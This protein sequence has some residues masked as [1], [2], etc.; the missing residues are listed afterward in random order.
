MPILDLRTVLISY[1]CGNLIC[2]IVLISLW[3]Q[4]RKRYS[5]LGYWS[6]CFICNLI[7]I[8]LLSGRGI[9]PDFFSMLLGSLF[10]VSGTFF[11]YVGLVVFLR[12]SRIEPHIYILMVVYLFLQVYFIYIKPNFE[13]RNILF[14]VLLFIFSIQFAWLLFKQVDASL[15]RFTGMLGVITCIFGL[16]AVL[17]I[18]LNIVIYPGSA[19]QHSAN[20]EAYL[21]LAFQL[22]YVILTIS[23]F[24]LVNR[25]LMDELEKDI[26][27][28]EEIEDALRLS[29]EKF[30]KA[31]QAS[32]NSILITRIS[33]GRIIDVNDRFTEVTGFKH[34][35]VIDKTTPMINFWVYPDDRNRM[36]QE[37]RQRLFVKNME[38]DFRVKSGSIFRGEISA[39][40]I[41]LGD[42]DCMLSAIQDVTERKRMEDILHL[43]LKLWE[44]SLTHTALEVMVKALDEIED[45]TGSQIGFY[46]LVEED[47]N[48]LTLQAWSTRTKNEYCHAEGSGM[49]Y[50]IDEAGIWVDCIRERKTVIHN[51]YAALPNKHGL[52]EG[53]SPLRRELLVPIFQQDQIVSV[54]GV[55]NKPTEYDQNDAE[56]VEYI[57]NLVWSIVAQKRADEKIQNL[58]EKL[59]SLAMVDEL[60][61]L[62]NRRAFFMRGA[63]EISRSKRYQ[64]PLTILMLDIDRFKNINDTYGHAI[65]DAALQCFAKTLRE[66]VREVD[67]P[68]RLG[69][70]EF[71]ILLP[72]TKLEEAQIIAERVRHAIE[73]LR[74]EKED[75]ICVTMTASIGA[76]EFVDKTKNLDDLFS[77]ADTAMYNAKN[78]GRNR[79]EVFE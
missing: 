53:H 2:A 44:Y 26:F 8:A 78:N 62:P 51:D 42:D 14:S 37:M 46:H 66:Q 47:T 70:E 39:E 25:R 11:L 69:G 7:G 31:F 21:Y 40:Y 9:I 5:G 27:K 59:A 6:V 38:F 28:R 16:L 58:N 1:I 15:R 12:K 19:P 56:F 50:S 75:N 41:K 71:G 29:R 18:V 10:L 54:L 57:A 76:A 67:V 36:V 68:A 77:N 48:T 34:D 52:P 49:H 32:P 55:G 3:L 30:A 22:L 61:N 65:G 43:R 79:V 73:L 20:Y 23:L 17:R 74:C 13:I 33:D 60:T 24:M 4:N 35:E 64:T 72:N 63:E 45:I